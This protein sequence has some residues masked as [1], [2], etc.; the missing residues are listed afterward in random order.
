MQTWER[1][2]DSQNVINRVCD[3]ILVH[4]EGKEIL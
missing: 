2:C 1:V 3:N 4:L